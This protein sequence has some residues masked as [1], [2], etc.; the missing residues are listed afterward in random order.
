MYNAFNAD[1]LILHKSIFHHHIQRWSRCLL[2]NS[3]YHDMVILVWLRKPGLMF[4]ATVT[5]FTLHVRGPS[6]LGLT[7][8]IS[9]LLMPWL[10]TSPGHQHPWYWLCRIGWSLAYLRK[11]LKY[12]GM[13]M[14][15]YA[16]N[17]NYM[18]LFL[19]KNLARKGLSNSI[20]IR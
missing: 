18:F 13:P 9:W 12:L 5:T 7:S 19:L 11:N 10:L 17:C 1:I 2:W 20:M 15:R 8:S 6:Y 4:G 16:K 14:W 3:C